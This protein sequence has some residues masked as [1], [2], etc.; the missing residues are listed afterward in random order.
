[1]EATNE[2]TAPFSAS[3][4]P[5][6]RNR[7][8]NQNSQRNPDDPTNGSSDHGANTG[9]QGGRR[10]RAP[11]RDVAVKQPQI[12]NERITTSGA[13]SSGPLGE[14]TTQKDPSAGSNR[15]GRN[16]RRRGGSRPGNSSGSASAPDTR[17]RPPHEGNR[18]GAK[19]NAGLTETPSKEASSSNNPKPSQRYKSS[20]PKGDDLT[21]TLIHALS[22]PP[23]P[24][25]PICF[26][27][28]HPA[29]PTW[30]CSRSL[31]NRNADD[32]GK[33][34]ESSQCCWTTFHLKCIR[35][36]ATKSVKELVDAW[37]ARGE[38]RP[39]EWRCPGCQS[40]REHV[41]SGYW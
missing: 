2:S 6:P 30:S 18:R 32:A 40:K 12:V 15:G 11:P 16:P 14:P 35:S 33:E 20:G 19:F 27:S 9:N 3:N 10:P 5:K 39:G 26:A 25:C 22:T 4:K 24:D 31:I 29:Q 21:S 41:P 13:S 37:R 38:E 7:H 1:M 23:Y 17:D 28:I 36:W 34:N 8:R